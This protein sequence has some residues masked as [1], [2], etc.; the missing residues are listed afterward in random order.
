MRLYAGIDGGQS[1]TTAL[2]AGEDGKI[3]GRGRADAADEVGQDERSTRARDA[4]DLALRAALAD[5]KLDA[6]T[7]FT[8]I[9][10]GLSGY[11]G[12]L[13]GALPAFNAEK[14]EI[15]HDAP[16]AHAAAFG[17]SDGVVVITG[18]GSV[19]YGTNAAG[20]TLRVGGWGYLFGDEG[21]AFWIGR[22]MLERAMRDAD[23]GLISFVAPSLLQY[24]GCADINAISRAFYTHQIDRTTIAGFAPVSFALAREGMHDALLVAEQAA[25]GIAALGALCARRL[26]GSVRVIAQRVPVSFAG[27]LTED[28]W[29][30]KLVH[31]KVRD[32]LPE[33]DVLTATQ[34][35]AAGALLLAYRAAGLDQLPQVHA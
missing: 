28:K 30:L 10:A 22:R 17:G 2:I 32:R 4:F 13:R 31:A 11:D 6:N 9:V 35:P 34:P 8:S 16:V 29:F 27:G 21:S 5:A 26:H 33:A 15:V 18:T 24:Y 1:S 3:L 25:D 12:K 19:A 14:F 23:S 7:R 20:E